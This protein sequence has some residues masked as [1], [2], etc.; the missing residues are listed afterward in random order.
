MSH[1][2]SD[3]MKPSITEVIGRYIEL[4]RAGKEWRGLC[5]FHDEK[6]PSFFVNEE[7]GV[8]HCFGCQWSGD[9]FDFVMGVEG[10][11]FKGARAHLGMTASRIAK[12]RKS[13]E[14]QAAEVITAWANEMSLKISARMRVLGHGLLGGE[15]IEGYC[16][17]Q[18]AILETL[19]QDLANP[20]LLPELWKQRESVEVIINA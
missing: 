15:P 8:A 18:W 9:V 19:D 17:R 14:R 11:D 13:P 3:N 20:R 4:K 10:L 16:E 7:K 12:P 5:P 2:V 1:R 6:T